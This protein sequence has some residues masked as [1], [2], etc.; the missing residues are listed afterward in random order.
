MNSNKHLLQ[1][2]DYPLLHNL[3]PSQFD[4]I[5]EY[6]EMISIKKG[7]SV[8]IENDE[9]DAV[10]FVISGKIK[11]GASLS[12]DQM[13]LKDIIQTG[14]LFGESALSAQN[15]RTEFAK[16]LCHKT[17][18]LKISS[19]ICKQIMTT[20]PQFTNDIIQYSLEKI[21]MLEKRI[22]YF[23]FKKAKA[24]IAQYIHNM[25]VKHG[26]KIGVDENL[27]KLNMSHKELAHITDTSRQT[28]ARVLSELKSADLIHFSKRKP[29][30]ILVRQLPKLA[31]L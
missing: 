27:I 4:S 28:V 22:E 8:Y 11:L 2:N 15:K 29:S 16:A 25:T 12:E 19:T 17:K 1:Q 10:F 23:I 5:V 18:V 24:R 7:T 21:Q 26:I 3:T 9:N 6:S 31:Q 20:N 14:G 30:K 13:V